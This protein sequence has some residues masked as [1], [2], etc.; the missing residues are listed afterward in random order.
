MPRKIRQIDGCFEGL[1]GELAVAHGAINPDTGEEQD[2]TTPL[3]N[4]GR[5]ASTSPGTRC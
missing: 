4:A 2:P 3:V 5:M 1:C